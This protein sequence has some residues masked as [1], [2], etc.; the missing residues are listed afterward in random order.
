MSHPIAH[1]QLE[2]ADLFEVF[3]FGIFVIDQNFVVRYWN[4]KMAEWMLTPAD[5]VIGEP[6][7]RYFPNFRNLFTKELAEQVFKDRKRV[8][9]SSASLIQQT[10][11][12]GSTLQTLTADQGISI[13]PFVNKE[14]GETLAIFTV[15]EANTLITRL[16]NYR[17]NRQSGTSSQPNSHIDFE[18]INQKLGWH[19]IKRTAALAAS[20]ER[21]RSLFDNVPAALFE[22]D[23]SEVRKTVNEWSLKNRTQNIEDFINSNTQKL[24]SLMEI[25]NANKVALTL[26]DT[27][28]F[29]ELEPLKTIF[30]TDESHRAFA[31]QLLAFLND[32]TSFV[33]EFETNL[34]HRRSIFVSYRAAIAPGSENHWSKILVGM[35]DITARREAEMALARAHA[36]LEK[37]V[38]ARTA[39]L[40]EANRALKKEIS[41][42]KAAENALRITLKEL[43]RSNR[44]LEEFASI[45]SHDLKEPLRKVRTFS[46]RL[47]KTAA[48]KLS[49][50][51]TDYLNRMENAIGRMENFI[52]S[53]LALSRVTSNAKPHE[54]VCLKK[55]V[56]EVLKDLE[57][58]IERTGGQ[59][60][61]GSLPTVMADAFQMQ[62][63]FQNLI[64]NALKFH[65]EDVPPKISLSAEKKVHDG[66]NFWTI[67]ICDNGI[68]IPQDQLNRIFKPFQR[69]HTRREYEGTGI[70]LAIC[71]K[72]VERHNGTIAVT[73]S[74]LGGS[75]FEITLP[76]NDDEFSNA[77]TLKQ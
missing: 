41:E 42:R 63:L 40:A 55:V 46:D 50:T 73:D 9:V 57:W 34:P 56:G 31:A 5:E 77:I 71:H 52:D 26:Y 24:I 68:G 4:H 51:E 29:S 17:I 58:Q 36:E 27:N 7:H 70:G 69:L 3:D 66:Q 39:E 53:L 28:L 16:Y 45:A 37:R 12:P 61:V 15:Q 38:E 59:V 32:Q 75:C 18:K 76:A 20:E 44:E 13:A 22:I 48:E 11:K 65:R 64:G 14:T 72:I 1:T 2:A 35:V 30:N 25:S 23:L 21:Y 67:R 74:Q 33:A 60:I 54:P 19:F 47:K 43:Q 8:K 49:Q 6:V 10:L 62:Q